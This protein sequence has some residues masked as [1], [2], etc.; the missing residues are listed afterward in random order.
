MCE[1]HAF[2]VK[3]GVEEK[4]LENVDMVEFEGDSVKLVSIF[5]EQKTIKGVLK[6]YNGS[7]G[8]ILFESR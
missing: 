1:A 8:K 2:F 3:D 7:E 4:I 6:S 5:G